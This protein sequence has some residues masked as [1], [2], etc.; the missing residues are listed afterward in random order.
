MKT[1]M[2]EGH[3]IHR[4]ALDLQK[5]FLAQRV[6]V[7]SPQGRFAEAVS[8]GSCTFRSAYAV[9]KHLFLVLDECTVHIHL[10]LFG[11]FK[12]QRSTTE[13]AS[14][15]VRLRIVSTIACWDLTGPT[16]C[17]VMSQAELEK[18]KA[19]LGADPLSSDSRPAKTWDKFHSSK[20]SVAALLLDQ[21]VFA[22]I[23]NVYRAELLFLVGL[24]PETPGN[25][26][27][28]ADFEK[29]WK[30]SKS[31]LAQGVKANRIVTVTGVSGRAPRRETL[32]VYK[33]AECRKCKKRIVESTN[34][35]RMMFHCPQCQPQR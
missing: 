20:R 9:G 28:K 16:A 11:K 31:L 5:D 15:T 14:N 13:V 21:S 34:A 17:C 33:R 29:L 6:V 30:L 19:R 22:G 27:S 10:G 4:L 24:H 35:T 3:T 12:R 8:I 18:L 23:G 26:V 7:S 32:Y 1:R 25:Q 2:P